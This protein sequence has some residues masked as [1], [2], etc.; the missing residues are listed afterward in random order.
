MLKQIGI[1]N[2][3]KDP[4]TTYTQAGMAITKFSIGC[5]V[6]DSNAAN[7]KGTEWVNCVAFNKT[8]ET[9]GKYLDKGSKIYFEGV[10]QTKKYERDGV[11]K[12]FTTTIINRIEF[13]DSRRDNNQQQQGEQTSNVSNDN[14]PF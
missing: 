3:G 14:L 13:L 9:I 5:S 11:V 1:G 10:P 4:E 7:K 6:Y 8:A 2:L 12:Y